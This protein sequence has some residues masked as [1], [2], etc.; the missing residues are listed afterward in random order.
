MKFQID[1][2]ENKVSRGKIS[3]SSV[4]KLLGLTSIAF[5]V[6]LLYEGVR[7]ALYYNSE[8]FIGSLMKAMKGLLFAFHA[9]CDY[10]QATSYV[11]LQAV[12]IFCT[13]LAKF[14]GF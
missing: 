4:P 8:G 14:H 7:C 3:T 9:K 13:L 12:R 5:S 10:K 6:F 2:E 11:S 1:F